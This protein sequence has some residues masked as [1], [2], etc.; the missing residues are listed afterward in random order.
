MVSSERLI[1]LCPVRNQG[2][3]RHFLHLQALLVI[4]PQTNREH[5]R[6]LASI[7]VQKQQSKTEFL[8]EN[9]MNVKKSGKRSFNLGR[10]QEN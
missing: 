2:F 1:I 8:T 7:T 5:F 9:Y 10:K 4:F 6:D 3:G